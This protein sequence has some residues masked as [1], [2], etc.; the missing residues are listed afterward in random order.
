MKLIAAVNEEW[1]IGCNGE[2]LCKIPEDMSFF[3]EMTLGKVVIMGNSTFKSLPSSK[4]LKDRINIVVSKDVNLRIQGAIVCGSLNDVFYI[5]N[6]CHTDD[7][8]VIGGQSIYKQLLPYCAVAYVTKLTALTQKADSF[9][10]NLNSMSNWKL[11]KT[12]LTKHYND[13]SYN[14]NV[15]ENSEICEI[16]RTGLHQVAFD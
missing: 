8:F 16:K 7:V 10:P 4:P 14:F 3:K 15:Y 5:S 1:G 12:S 2:L 13:I 9:F 11:I 6:M